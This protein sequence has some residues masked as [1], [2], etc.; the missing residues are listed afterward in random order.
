MSWACRDLEVAAVGGRCDRRRGFSRLE[1]AP[2]PFLGRAAEGRHSGQTSCSRAVHE[3]VGQR[4]G[5]L[6]SPIALEAV[7]AGWVAPAG[8][9]GVCIC[10]LQVLHLRNFAIIN[11]LQRPLFRA[12]SSL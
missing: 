11:V 4:D 3:P 9:Y 2:S 12:S 5:S 8:C 10:V 6:G 1:R 7:I